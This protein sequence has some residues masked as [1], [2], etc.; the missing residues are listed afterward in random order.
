MDAWRALVPVECKTCTAFASCHGG[1]RAV[2]QLRQDRRDPLRGT[3]LHTA[4]HSTEACELP[5]HAHPLFVGRLRDETFGYAVLGQGQVVAVRRE[6]YQV[7]ETCTGE[8]TLL[9]LKESLALQVSEEFA[10]ASMSLLHDLW[11]VGL[12]ELS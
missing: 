9:E 4:P 8:H 1:C 10:E 6:A 7:L 12:I 11:S 2:Q 3:P 5:A